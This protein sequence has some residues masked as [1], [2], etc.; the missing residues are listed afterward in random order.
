M[1]KGCMKRSGNLRRGFEGA[2]L[3]EGV[4]VKENVCLR[5]RE[6]EIEKKMRLNV[7]AF[8]CVCIYKEE[9]LR[10]HSEIGDEASRMQV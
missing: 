4:C 1:Y 5:E 9:G 6:K 8:A 3:K 10:K 2:G 7:R